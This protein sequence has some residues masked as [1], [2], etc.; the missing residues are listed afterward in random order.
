[1]CTL[2]NCR[3]I[4]C[5]ISCVAW[6]F[7]ICAHEFSLAERNFKEK[8]PFVQAHYHSIRREISC[9]L[10]SEL[11]L[12]NHGNKE[13][14]LRISLALL[15][16]NTVLENR[17]RKQK[18]PTRFAHVH[19]L[20][21]FQLNRSRGC[22]LGVEKI[23]LDFPKFSFWENISSILP[24]LMFVREGSSCNNNRRS[25]GDMQQAKSLHRTWQKYTAF[26]GWIKITII[27]G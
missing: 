6:W 9:E 13:Q 15:L 11:S 7:I 26:S 8:S 22:R 5:K 16:C 17:K 4:R 21:I 24:T 3:S 20:A 23:T 27:R 19:K 10:S 2:P 1:M 14:N 12:K 18:L 25:T